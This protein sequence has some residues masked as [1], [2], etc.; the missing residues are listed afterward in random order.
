MQHVAYGDPVGGIFGAVA[1]L[2]A[3]YA[4]RK[5]RV[6][7]WIDLGQV[8]CLFQLCAD[9]VIAQSL[10]PDKLPP[11]GSA[12]PASILRACVPT[13][14]PD[15]WLAVS[16]ETEQQ[17]AK[18]AQLVGEAAGLE[19]ALASWSARLSADEVAARL[20]EA[21]VPA[22]PVR[23]AHD[24]LDDPQLREAGFWQRRERRFVG[25]HVVPLAPYRL[26]GLPPPL[27]RV[28]PTLGEHNAE[29]LTGRAG[30]GPAELTRLERL[31][32]IGTR[33]ALRPE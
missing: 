26:D 16:V 31:S 8:E 10:R 12:H 21:G 28:A 2:T 13:A 7:T 22:A 6:G 32:V 1:C 15:E 14:R 25:T 23:P 11:E 9:A 29:I 24:L 19:A 4:G 33:A 5:R 3:L 20:Q 30:L 17:R 27:K 18:L